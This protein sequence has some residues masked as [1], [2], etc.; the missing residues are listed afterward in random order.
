MPKKYLYSV[1]S[2]MLVGAG[3]EPKEKRP[4]IREKYEEKGIDLPESQYDIAFP[5]H[6]AKRLGLESINEAKSGSGTDYIVRTMFEW[7]ENNPDKID[8]TIFLIEASWGIR[9]DWYVKK[10]DEFAIVN[11]AKNQNGE[12]PFTLVKEW[13][14]DTTEELISWENDFKE[15]ITQYFN[16]FYDEDIFRKLEDS[17]FL[18]FLSY[19]NQRGIDYIVSPSSIKDDYVSDE[20]I[21]II[22]PDRNINN[23]LSDCTIWRYCQI[24]GWLIKDE[25]DYNEDHIGLYGNEHI[26]EKLEDYIRKIGLV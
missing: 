11:A 21:K 13:F 23:F 12:Y 8:E 9:L 17:K 19:L 6:L 14:L 5:T 25:V 4:E 18:F 26:A 10:W 24:N 3:F 2:S 7:I 1:G 20:I 15:P 16:N 22:P